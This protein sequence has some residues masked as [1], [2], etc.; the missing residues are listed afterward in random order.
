MEI[1]NDSPTKVSVLAAKLSIAASAIALLALL[2]LHFLSPEFNPSWRVVSE[3]ALGQY[4]LMLSAFFLIWGLGSFFAAISVWPL[5]TGATGKAGLCLLFVSAIG[6]T[7][8]AFF[9]VKHSMHG[10]AAL[11]GVPTLPIAAMLISY[12]LVRKYHIQGK[13]LL[14]SANFT[15]LI[16]ILMVIAMVVML[17]GFA[18]AGLDISGNQQVS[19]K[20][21]EGV[22]AVAGYTNRLLVF[23]NILWLI[24]VSRQ[25]IRFRKNDDR[26]EL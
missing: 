24:V 19:E 26:Q 13:F 11:L 2:S 21:P 8:A 6:G 3:Y 17:S 22:I 4:P 9:D 15:W 1:A 18:K 5:I 25:V 7:M 16:L 20:V 14:L 10:M 23:I 12:S